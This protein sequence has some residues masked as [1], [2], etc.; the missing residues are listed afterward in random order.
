MPRGCATGWTGWAGWVSLLVMRLFVALIPPVGAIEDLGEF[1]GPRQAADAGAPALRWTEPFQWHVT[2]AFLPNAADRSLD[3]LEERL[4]RAAARRTPFDAVIA[5]A[6]AFPHVWNA[7]VVWAGVRLDGDAE[8]EELRR[9]ST[10]AR[11]AA[12]KAGCEVA[13]G[14]FRPHVTLARS[15]RPADVT[16]W[17]RVLETYAGPPWRAT[18]IALV[19]S[20]LGEGPRGRPRY[21]IRESF[22]LGRAVGE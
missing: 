10:G 2:L 17:I 12:A 1:L 16:R 21:D 9:L 20:H 14:A 19:E 13:G 8:A 7:S 3:E 15:P 6:G 22:R 11:S 18:E 5:G 4:S